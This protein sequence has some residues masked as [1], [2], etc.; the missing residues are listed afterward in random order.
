MRSLR[1]ALA[2][3][4]TAAST[5]GGQGSGAI[6]GTYTIALCQQRPCAVG[7]T[8]NVIVSGTLIFADSVISVA[9]W[10][11][12]RRISRGAGGFIRSTLNACLDLTTH[13]S[14]ELT[15]VG[16]GS[17]NLFHWERAS[18]T[19]ATAVLYQSPDARGRLQFTLRGDTLI[20]SG[21]SDG[22]IGGPIRK[23]DDIVVGRRLGPPDLSRCQRA[24]AAARDAEL[25]DPRGRRFIAD[26]PAPVDRQRRY[27]L[28]FT[29]DSGRVNSPVANFRISP[30]SMAQV[31]LG[32]AFAPAGMTVIAHPWNVPIDS[33]VSVA[34]AQVDVLVRTGVPSERISVIGVGW[35]ATPAA[36]MAARAVVPLDYVFVG[37]C[38]SPLP[39]TYGTP[40]R[41]VLDVADSTTPAADRCGRAFTGVTRREIP[42]SSAVMS[43]RSG[44]WGDLV[45]EW[46]KR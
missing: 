24:I 38:S 35:G 27:V 8:T 42:T 44:D 12:E 28:A 5:I 23:R 7:D 2:T 31:T 22:M 4:V 11:D 34:L 46:M 21:F 3:A 25:A 1:I 13:R 16:I 29:D 39:T 14:A 15:Y 18:D 37:R 30:S 10:P 33:L 19:S 9:G 41:R 26:L 40:P 20:G 32:F 43:R 45:R 6:A 17:P 36:A